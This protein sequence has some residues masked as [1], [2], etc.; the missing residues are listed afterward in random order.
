MT[1]AERMLELTSLMG[2]NTPAEHFLSITQ[3]GG[4]G[5]FI[6]SELGIDFAELSAEI[7]N[8]INIDIDEG[9]SIS[10]RGSI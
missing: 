1:P 5:S 6:A 4:A 9:I 2:L 7:S 3:T 10:I 8:E